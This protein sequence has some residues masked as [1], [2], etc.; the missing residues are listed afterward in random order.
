MAFVAKHATLGSYRSELKT[1]RQRHLVA[2]AR[3]GGAHRFDNDEVSSSRC[4]RGLQRLATLGLRAGLLSPRSRILWARRRSCPSASSAVELS[5]GASTSGRLA[6]EASRRVAEETS[7]RF[8]CPADSLTH[9]TRPDGDEAFG[10]FA[11][12]PTLWSGQGLS[13]S[14]PTTPREELRSR[15]AM[16]EIELAARWDARDRDSSASEDV[17]DLT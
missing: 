14:A 1:K 2:G 12:A 3:G 10:P 6:E 7:R 15:S 17:S 8:V 16:M 13:H 5:V 4:S 9:S 11:P